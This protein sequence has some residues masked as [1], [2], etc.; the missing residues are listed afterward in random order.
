MTGWLPSPLIVH[1]RLGPSKRDKK[2]GGHCSHILTVWIKSKDDLSYGQKKTFLLWNMCQDR[3]N[4]PVGIANQN[5]GFASFCPLQSHFL[6]RFSYVRQVCEQACTIFLVRVFSAC[7]CQP[8][9]IRRHPPSPHLWSKTR[10]GQKLQHCKD[11]I[12]HAEPRKIQGN[13]KKCLNT[14]SAHMHNK[15]INFRFFA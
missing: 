10:H 12:Q 7:A 5:T 4:F 6:Q 11:I 8:S 13:V 1:F 14:I 9:M 2:A 3:S 15:V